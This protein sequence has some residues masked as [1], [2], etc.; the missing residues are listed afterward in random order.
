M[1]W[2]HRL[3]SVSVGI[4]LMTQDDQ[5]LTSALARSDRALYRAKQQGR[6]RFVY[7]PNVAP[8]E[9]HFAPRMSLRKKRF[10][11]GRLLARAKRLRTAAN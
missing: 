9:P 1:P 11:L 10:S 4:S 6:D 3:I 7:L 2:K 8:S 5:D